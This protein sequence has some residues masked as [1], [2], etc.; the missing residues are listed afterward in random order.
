MLMDAAESPDRSVS[1]AT[2][3]TRRRTANAL[4]RKGLL[5]V[6]SGPE[7][8]WEPDMWAGV[9]TAPGWNAVY[10]AH[11]DR[12]T[13]GCGGQWKPDGT[14]TG[15][16]QLRQLDIEAWDVFLE[17]TGDDERKFLEHRARLW[18]NEHGFARMAD[19]TTDKTCRREGAS[20]YHEQGYIRA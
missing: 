12:H 6:M 7:T 5:T 11:D 2:H 8:G 17:A 13:P 15:C 19:W 18:C 20:P 1:D 14:C 16:R 3:K 4:A 10:R 9:I